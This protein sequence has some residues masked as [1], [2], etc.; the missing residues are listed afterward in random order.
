TRCVMC[1]RCVLVSVVLHYVFLVSFFCFFFFFFFSSRR[2]HTRFSHDWSS[3]VCSSDLAAATLRTFKLS[4]PRD[5]G[6]IVFLSGGQS[7]KD[8]KSTRLNSSHV[9]ISYAVFCLKKKKTYIDIYIYKS[10]HLFI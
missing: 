7:A 1:S 6:G 4:V 9:K 10:V 5:V 2:R 3:D 8:R